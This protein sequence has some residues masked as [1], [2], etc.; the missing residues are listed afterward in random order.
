[1]RRRAHACRI[2]VIDVGTN[3]TKLVVG[4]VR[5][6]RVATIHV[7]R[8]PS[9]LGER[10]THTGKISA[11][12]TERTA[13]DVHTLSTLARSHGAEVVVAVGTYAFRT[14]SNGDVV[15]RR[16]ARRAGVPLRVLSGREEAMLAYLSVLTRLSRPKAYTFLIDVGGGSTEFVAARS[17]RLVRARSLPL[18]ALRLTERRLHSDPIAPAER[19]ALEREVDAA[20][21]RVVAPFRRVPASRIDLVASGGSATTAVAMLSP[22]ARRTPTTRLS[23]RRVQVLAD[24]CFART[25]AQRKRLR[26][27]PADR[28]DIMPAGLAVV[29]AFM[30]HAGK[31]TLVVSDGGIREGVLIAIDAELRS[32]A[33]ER[34]SHRHAPRSR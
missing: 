1:M 19:R 18:G 7:A 6:D 3:S 15:A 5:G 8:R 4:A 16:I 2:G 28:A 11:A 34:H 32:L 22:R 12:A 26:G 25:I 17:G 29:L 30:R 33:H 23:R 14:A 9:R 13:R 31:R 10:L 27:L 24:A 20:V 21:S